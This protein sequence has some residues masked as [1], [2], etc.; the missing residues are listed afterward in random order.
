MEWKSS[1]E[2]KGPDV[3]DWG[4]RRRRGEVEVVVTTDWATAMHVWRCYVVGSPKRTSSG[5]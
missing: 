4:K 2:K 5:S 3:R 1:K